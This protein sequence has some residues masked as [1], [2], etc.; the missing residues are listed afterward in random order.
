[1]TPDKPQS[2][3]ALLDRARRGDEEAFRSLFDRH[4]GLLE[5]RVRR[6]LPP[7]L[8]RKL[9]VADVVQEARLLTFTK[10][11]EYDPEKGS[12]RNWLVGIGARKAREAARH[13]LRTA[14]RAA[15]REVTRG[16]R[17]DT[18]NFA[19]QGPT[20]SEMAVASELAERARAARETLPEDYSEIL[21]LAHE[22]GLDLDEAA[23]RMGRSRE[24]VKKLYGR[25]LCRF[26]E[27]FRAPGENGDV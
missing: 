26:R 7:R 23:L 15:D 25:A 5:A 13:Y 14:K 27:V 8:S 2:D 10:L 6:L 4:R 19:G 3:E 24:A 16:E 22:E 9:S 12:F 1:V 20:P 18:A 11:P 21:R 17:V